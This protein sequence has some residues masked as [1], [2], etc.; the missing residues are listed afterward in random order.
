MTTKILEPPSDS[1]VLVRTAAFRLL[2]TRAE[3]IGVEELSAKSGIGPERLSGLLDHL[4]SAGRIR[5]NAAGKVVGSAGLSVVPDRH[6]IELDGRRFWTWCAYDILGIFGALGANGRAS[7]PS[8][9][10]GEPIVLDFA[11]GRPE[12]NAAVLFRPD[13]EL[14]SSCE[15][16]YEEWCPNSNIFA[17][18]ELATRWANQH[19]VCGRIFDLDEASDLATKDW[20]GVI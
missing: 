10:D 4:D 19:T 15:N 3:P 11:Q 18:R 8:P 5:R 7:S 16:V 6:E 1:Q 14:M 12:K 9:P 2:L 17:T 13:E 20:G